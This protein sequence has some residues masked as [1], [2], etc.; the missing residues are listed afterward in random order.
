MPGGS[1]H[2]LH[3]S[4]TDVGITSLGG[5][6]LNDVIELKSGKRYRLCQMHTVIINNATANGEVSEYLAAS[7]TVVTQ[8]ISISA[9]TSTSDVLGVGIANAAFL[10]TDST[11]TYYGWFQISGHHAAAL[12]DTATVAGCGLRPD[13]ATDG[14]LIVIATGADTRSH[15]QAFALTDDV[16][17]VTPVLCHF[18]A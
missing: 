12:T 17:G 3:R 18:P 4:V 1:T 13:P 7:T 9:S 10:E 11:N 8:D 5:Q 14:K 15:S 16:A 6:S 2:V